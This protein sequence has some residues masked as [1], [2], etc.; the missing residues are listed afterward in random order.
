MF[1][2]SNPITAVAN[3]INFDRAGLF[4][5]DGVELEFL[6]RD[7]DEIDAIAFFDM[8]GKETSKLVGDFCLL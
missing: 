2:A 8:F 1:D 7:F 4:G 3:G 5:S 6:L